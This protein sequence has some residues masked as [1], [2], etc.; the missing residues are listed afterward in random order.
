VTGRRLQ[1]ATLAAVALAGLVVVHPL[2]VRATQTAPEESLPIPPVPPVH[3][4]ADIAA[5]VPNADLYAPANATE[6]GVTLKPTLNERAPALPG[7]DPVP[8][9]LYRSE[10]EQRRQY[11]PS[12]GFR[13]VVPLEK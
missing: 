12:P 1:A 7:G 11:I 2:A 8:G 5:P 4:P 3:P 9:T 10:E 6:D 13:L